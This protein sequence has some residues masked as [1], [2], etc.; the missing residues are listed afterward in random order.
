[1]LINSFS[2]PDAGNA[3]IGTALYLAASAFDHSCAPNA[4]FAFIDGKIVVKALEDIDLDGA[5]EARDK[6][7]LSYIDPLDGARYG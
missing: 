3:G 6:V 4:A 2:Y 7:T 5:E 1:M